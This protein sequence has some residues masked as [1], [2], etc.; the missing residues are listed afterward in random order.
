MTRLDKSLVCL[1]SLECQGERFA[2]EALIFPV[3]PPLSPHSPQKRACRNE[4]NDDSPSAYFLARRRGKQTCFSLKECTIRVRQNVK[5]AKVRDKQFSMPKA[6]VM[7]PVELI[8]C[9][10]K[11]QKEREKKTVTRISPVSMQLLPNTMISARCT[12]C[13]CTGP[14]SPIFAWGTSVRNY[15]KDCEGNRPSIA[16]PA[17]SS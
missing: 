3:S 16:N 1:S 6:A 7:R 9:Y 17:R 11:P 2:I 10:S 4:Q 14:F 15:L 8:I 5:E 12:K 13:L